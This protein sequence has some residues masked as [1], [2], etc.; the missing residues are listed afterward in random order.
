MNKGNMLHIGTFLMMAALLLC[1]CGSPQPKIGLMGEDPAVP[2]VFLEPASGLVIEFSDI[3]YNA[4]TGYLEE[5]KEKI[6]L[7]SGETKE[8]AFEDLVYAGDGTPTDYLV[9]INGNV[10][11]NSS[12]EESDNLRSEMEVGLAIAPHPLFERASMPFGP[13][14]FPCTGEVGTRN[15]YDYTDDGLRQVARSKF[16]C[17]IQKMTYKFDFSDYKY[18][19]EALSGFTVEIE[20]SVED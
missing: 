1:G 10:V 12:K 14:I 5:Y 4:G 18:F 15:S 2:S 13:T 19:G 6:I 8:V 7:P 11:E 9:T 17:G 20:R 3:S 16:S